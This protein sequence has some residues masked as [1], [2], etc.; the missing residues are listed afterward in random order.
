MILAAPGDTGYNVMLFLHIL[1]VMAA[2][3][4]AFVHPVLS[5]QSKALTS[6]Q[7]TVLG[8]IAQNSQRIYS[9]ALIVA[10]LLGFGLAGMSDDVYSLG[11]GWLIASILVWVAMNGVLHAI[12][13][14]AEKAWAAGD[15]SAEQKV[16]MGGA[17]LTLLMLVML[18]LMIFKPGA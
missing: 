1:F 3:A 7:G 10:G 13:I 8:F 12:Q 4:P 16:Q 14:P 15:D 6:E 5:T 17:I 11:D 2:F 9:V 18:Y